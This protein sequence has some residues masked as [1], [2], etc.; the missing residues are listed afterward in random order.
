MQAQRLYINK[1]S[2][3][4][5]NKTAIGLTIQTFDILDP[6]KL[7]C[8]VSNDITLPATKN[9]FV[10]FGLNSINFWSGNEVYETQEI[11][12]Y[13]GNSKLLTGTCYIKEV[14]D[15]IKIVMTAKPTVWEV[16]KKYT[17]AQF[18][19]DFKDWINSQY[20]FSNISEILNYL[21]FGEYFRMMYVKGHLNETNTLTVNYNEN[22]TQRSGGYL[23][24]RFQYLI[25]Y[26]SIK[27]GV[28][29]ILNALP[30]ESIFIPARTLSINALYNN[31]G[32]QIGFNIA[33][34]TA[35]FSEVGE[36]VTDKPNI[37]IYDILISY[38]KSFNYSINFIDSK[39]YIR[40]FSELKNTTSYDL[41]KFLANK[42]TTFT[43]ILNGYS[44]TNYIK[45][46]AYFEGAD[47][48]THSKVLTCQND[49]IPETNDLYTIEKT[50]YPYVYN[51]G[52]IVTTDLSV[53]ESFDAIT[54]VRA[55][56]NTQVFTVNYSDGIGSS[57]SQFK[58]LSQADANITTVNFELFQQMIIKPKLYTAYFYLD[59]DFF[60]TFD[61]LR[62]FYV[63]QLYG[64]FFINKIEGYNPQSKDPVKM[65]LLY[66]SAQLPPAEDQPI[67]ADG[68]NNPFTDGGSNQPLFY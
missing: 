14:S 51:N 6:S 25:Q 8:I 62:Q 39:V 54:F 41:T 60:V 33:N 15:R 36:N 67:W 4:L 29:F 66:C 49:N 13:V 10:V 52:N 3:D 53:S 64:S 7:K 24:I 45:K 19:D 11:E 9:N 27:T 12:Y 38:C 65:E 57:H 59:F 58:S 68:I 22:Y 56:D 48:N 47:E 5:D 42:P 30:Y 40:H 31:S 18:V 23:F 1:K 61:P 26:L 43:P 21:A 44:K 37:N 16:L 17:W 20:S 2:I 34:R 50:Y 46:A 55:S 32:A 63:R 28:Q 35:P